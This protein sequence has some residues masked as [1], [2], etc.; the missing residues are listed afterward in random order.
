MELQF[1]GQYDQAL[2]YKAVRLA[3]QPARHQVRFLWFMLMFAVGALVLLLYRVFETRDLA[4]NA[5]L[6]GAAMILAIVV[7]GIFLQPYLTARRLWANPGTRRELIGK[8]TNRE[9]TYILDAGVNE[10]RWER[11]KRVRKSEDLIT[12][13]RSDGLLVIFPRRF[14]R[15]NADWRKFLRLVEGKLTS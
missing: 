4:G 2:F 1:Q 9:I 10:I 8:I 3:N 5:I 13:V 12:L 6:L 14:F 15:N 11:F 7:S